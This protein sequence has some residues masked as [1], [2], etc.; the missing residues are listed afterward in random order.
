MARYG[1][2]ID[3]T[4]CNGCYNCFLACKDE[5][6]GNEFP[7][8]SLSQPDTGHYWM[9]IVERER[10]KYPKVKVSY[11]PIPCMQCEDA[12]CVKASHEGEIYKRPDGIVIID[13][14]KSKGKKHLLSSCPYRVI[15]W[16][17]E[18][19][20]PQKCI[21]CA[22]LLDNGWKKPRCVEVCPSEALIFGDIDNPESE[23]SKRLKSNSLESLHPEYGLKERV[24]YAGL[25]KV[26]V[27]GSVVLGDK[28]ECA[29]GAKVTLTGT[30]ERKVVRTNNFGDFEFE[31]LDSKKTYRLKV[32]QKGYE[33]YQIEVTPKTDVYLGDIILKKASKSRKR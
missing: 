23:I 9:K 12:P 24:L 13:P 28:D 3:V 16:N 11:I 26:F 6:C 7:H 30:K 1:M 4:R 33:S 8:Y 5:F 25:P 14:E 27:A 29:N 32:E 2:I 19:Q 10:G 31:G 20:V 22:H 17:E 15:Y 18:K 21:F